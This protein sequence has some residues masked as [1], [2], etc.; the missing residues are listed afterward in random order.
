MLRDGRDAAVSAFHHQQRILSKLGQTNPDASLE[1]E[2]PA[3][4]RKWA[5]FTRAVQKAEQA[6]IR[7]RTVHYE[8]MLA[9]PNKAL[10][11]CLE[12]IAPDTIWPET[13]IQKN[14][15]A[16][17]FR[18]QSGRKP[19]QSSNSSFLRKGQAGS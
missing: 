15:E 16:N 4:L 1:K 17:S 14:V 9:D 10:G 3:W 19:G 5:R 13:D 6:G 18:S 7:I 11:D 12:H 2:A 8:A